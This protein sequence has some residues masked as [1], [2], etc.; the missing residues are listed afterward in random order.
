MKTNKFTLFSANRFAMMIEQFGYSTEADM[1]FT[2]LKGISSEYHRPS[3]QHFFTLQDLNSYRTLM[4]EK[5]DK[6]KYETDFDFI[7]FF[8]KT[9]SSDDHSITEEDIDNAV[10][11]YQLQP[12]IAR[13]TEKII[14]KTEGS[15]LA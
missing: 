2:F 6:G 4:L 8:F 14:Q 9:V 12:E 13:Q 7:K 15:A 3:N 1:V 10:R 5:Q 11:A